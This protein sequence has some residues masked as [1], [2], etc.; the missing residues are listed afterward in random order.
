M[1]RWGEANR[2]PAKRDRGAEARA[3]IARGAKRR[4]VVAQP[5]VDD[6]TREIVDGFHVFVST[7]LK[8]IGEFG[9]SG[10]RC[11]GV[12]SAANPPIFFATNRRA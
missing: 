2:F 1:A 10:T 4:P 5:V 11:R 12:L 8:D 6:E 7:T 3:L 9:C